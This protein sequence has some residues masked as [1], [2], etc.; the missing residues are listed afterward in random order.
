V[1]RTLA[2]FWRQL[3][4]FATAAARR[5]AR[6]AYAYLEKARREALDLVW[7]LDAP[8]SWPSGFEKL[9]EHP[10]TGAGRTD[11]ADFGGSRPAV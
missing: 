4:L 5:R 6:T 7:L 2:W 3:S 9:E 11:P 10:G 8:G 1:K